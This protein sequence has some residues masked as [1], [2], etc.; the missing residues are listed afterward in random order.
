MN[1]PK[2][3][4]VA[5]DPFIYHF[6]SEGPQGRIKKAVIYAPIED[7]IFNLAFGDWNEEVRRIDDSNRS[8]NRDR[9]KVLATVAFTTLDF[10]NRFPNASIFAEGTTTARTRLYQMGIGNNLLEINKYF[11]IEGFAN[12]EWE[13]FRHG[14][15]Y[16][17]FLIGRK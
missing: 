4:V 3:P 6:Y 7:D 5:R 10:T 1:L 12:G 16:E 9:D 17:A 15:N 14:K 13:R 8:N 11:E 2:Y